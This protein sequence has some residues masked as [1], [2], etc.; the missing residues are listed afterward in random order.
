MTGNKYM[1]GVL[2]AFGSLVCGM[3]K[4]HLDGHKQTVKSLGVPYTDYALPF[5]HCYQCS[6]CGRIREAPV[7][8]RRVKK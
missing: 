7:P 6:R 8:V 5:T 4:H 3:K 1:Q 2:H